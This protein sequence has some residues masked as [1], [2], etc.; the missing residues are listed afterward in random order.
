M[1]NFNLNPE[2]TAP[3]PEVVVEAAPEP[4]VVVEAAPEP[5][6][7]VEAAP[8]PEVVVEAAPEPEASPAAVVN[9]KGFI[10]KSPSQWAIEEIEHGMISAYNSTTGERFEGNLS[11]FNANLRG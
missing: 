2:Q 3:E 9:V 6:V 11:D 4:E 7:V 8:E 1:K 5:E 10:G